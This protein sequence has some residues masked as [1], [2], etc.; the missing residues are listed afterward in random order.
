MDN[1]ENTYTSATGYVSVKDTEGRPTRINWR[2]M[3]GEFSISNGVSFEA[4]SDLLTLISSRVAFIEQIM[5]DA[6]FSQNVTFSEMTTPEGVLT[7]T[8]DEQP[9]NSTTTF[10]GTVENNE[11]KNVEG[12]TPKT[13]SEP[14]EKIEE[15]TSEE[16]EQTVE[17]SSEGTG[18]KVKRRRGRPRK[19]D[20]AD[21]NAIEVTG[22]PEPVVSNSAT[23]PN[24]LADAKTLK[25]VVKYFIDSGTTDSDEIFQKCCEVK[26][27][28][29]IL[30]RAANLN[31][32]VDRIAK[33]YLGGA[34]AV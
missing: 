34:S 27:Q 28:V 7:I 30:Q 1:T 12:T 18:A 9:S 32:R 33:V 20:V 23:V 25:S 13:Q 10:S 26:E 6:E 15:R 4:V 11:I 5:P 21:E 14:E 17:S 31:S 24:E 19:S 22:E 2:W 16:P 29:P 3:D 8:S